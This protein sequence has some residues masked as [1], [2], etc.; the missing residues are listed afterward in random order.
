MIDARAVVDLDHDGAVGDPPGEVD[1]PGGHRADRRARGVPRCRARRGSA[2]STCPRSRAA[3]R[4]VK[5]VG[6]NRWVILPRAAR[7]PTRRTRSGRP[8]A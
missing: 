2:R 3:A 8:S 5:L 7:R 1:P 4:R 6:P